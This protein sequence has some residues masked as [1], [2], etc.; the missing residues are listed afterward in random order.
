MSMATILHV[1]SGRIGRAVA[2]VRE[3]PGVGIAIGALCLALAIRGTNRDI[4]TGLVAFAALELC[5]SRR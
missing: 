4:A 1:V 5:L 3:H 2:Y